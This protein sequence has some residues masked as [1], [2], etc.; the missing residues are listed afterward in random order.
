VNTLKRLSL[1]SMLLTQTLTFALASNTYADELGPALKTPIV[2]VIV[3]GGMRP[4]LS[5]AGMDNPVRCTKLWTEIIKEDPIFQG[6]SIENAMMSDPVDVAFNYMLSQERIAAFNALPDVLISAVNKRAIVT[7]LSAVLRSDNASARTP[8]EFESFSNLIGEATISQLN[9]SEIAVLRQIFVVPIAGASATSRLRELSTMRFQKSPAT[10]EIF[11]AIVRAAQSNAGGKKPKIGLITAAADNPYHEHDVNYYG[12]TSAGAEVAW[13]PLDGGLRR[14]LDRR[15]C[16][17]LS[18]YAAAYSNKASKRPHYHSDQLFPDL[19]QQHQAYCDN[20]GAKL[21]ALVDSLDGVFFIGGDQARILDS[22]TQKDSQSLNRQ[23]STQL[24]ILQKRHAAGQLVISGTSAGD[25]IQT[26]GTQNGKPLPMIAGGDSWKTLVYGYSVVDGVDEDNSEDGAKLKTGIYF[27]QGGL[28]F[29]S[30]GILDSHFSKRTREARLT[31]LVA[32]SGARYGF[33]VDEN[34]AML[35]HQRDRKG[36]TAIEIIGEAGVFIIDV[37]IAQASKNKDA[38]YQI[39]RARAHYVTQGDTIWID[40][41]GE[42]GIQFARDKSTLPINSNQ[43]P[44]KQ[45]RVM[46]YG[47]GHFLKMAQQMGKTGASTAL[48]TSEESK[49]QNAPFYSAKLERDTATAFSGDANGR[50]SY[51][52]VLLS[53]APCADLCQLP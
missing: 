43:A 11:R 52:N 49:G 10:G 4:C 15:D 32:E 13:I 22:F 28:G 40:K 25:A 50:I 24:Q 23:N 35:V 53:F 48:G 1:G 9:S 38:L 45:Q 46:E 44:I 8:M 19:A 30:Y 47:T 34:T 3:G 2:N 27:P 17:N 36:K 6:I 21:N 33:G 12:F 51:R 16:G 18:L 39:L 41:R 37:N 20:T 14:A 42:L 31:R 5:S 26:G 7:A 29:F